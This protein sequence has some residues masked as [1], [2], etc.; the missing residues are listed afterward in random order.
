MDA[1]TG[2]DTFTTRTGAIAL[3]LAI[4]VFVVSTAIHPS[5]EA[6][7]DNPAI[8]MEYAQSDGWIAIHF[9]Q[10]LGVLLLFSGFVALY[11]SITTKQEAAA[12]VARFGF[13]AAVL[14]AAS[15]T[16]LQAIDGVTLK[17]AV[18]AWVTA[19]ADLKAAAF[20]AAEVARWTEYATQSYSNILLGLTLLLYGLAIA[21]GTVYPRWLGWIAAG[22]GVAWIIHGL[23]VPYIGLFNSIPRLVALVLMAVWAFIMGYLM[24]RDGSRGRIRRTQSATPHAPPG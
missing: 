14:T 6:P 5:R 19:P 9:A 1:R 21:L 17:W 7:M 18:D 22:S 8:F 10:W 23:M 16:M 20:T 24:W 13:G 3:P 4:I 2:A 15:L 11:Y 12:G